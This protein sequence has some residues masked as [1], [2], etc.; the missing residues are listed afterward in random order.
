[1]KSFIITVLL[2][3]FLTI[4]TSQS[5]EISDTGPMYSDQEIGIF[6]QAAQCLAIKASPE[7]KKSI[8]SAQILPIP[9][10]LYSY[11]NI[12]EPAYDKASAS[13]SRNIRKLLGEHCPNSA[14][15]LS[16][17]IKHRSPDEKIWLKVI[18]E[19]IVSAVIVQQTLP[20]SK[21]DELFRMDYNTNFDK[22]LG[23]NAATY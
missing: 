20:L 8:I 19:N 10:N 17:A 22:V 23:T 13:D 5:K 4:N 11:D 14:A 3:M 2:I 16:K 21:R 6:L 12:Y 9:R 1:M 7:Q 15:D 18:L